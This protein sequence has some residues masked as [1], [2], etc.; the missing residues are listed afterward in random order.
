MI[1]IVLACE[2]KAEPPVRVYLEEIKNA[3]LDYQIICW[4][5][6]SDSPIHKN[7]K[8]CIEFSYKKR[9]GSLSSKLR[10]YWHFRRF[11]TKQLKALKPEKI[12]FIPTQ[13]GILLPARFFKK[14]DGCYYFDYRD[15]G[16]EKYGFYRKRVMNM[17]RHSF[18]TAISSKGFLEV[19][20]PSNKYVIAH[21]GYVYKAKKPAPFGGNP[22]YRI[23]SI[24]TLRTPEFV[25][26]E[27][28]PFIHDE[29]FEVHLYGT[30]DDRTVRFL[31]EKLDKES[32]GNVFYNG[33]FQDEELAS[34]IDGSDAL[35]VYYLSKIDGLYHMPDRLYLGLEYSKPMIANSETYCSRYLQENGIGYG[36]DPRRPDLDG[37]SRFLSSIN[38][39]TIYENCSTCL[40]RI[41]KENETW[42]TSIR[43]FLKK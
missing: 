12:I 8:G 10:N 5:P 16:Y 34:I 13:A 20:E 40:E 22:P 2:V 42:R 38:P 15:P 39:S 36:L 19:L 3:G 18:A 28:A 32:I 1:A 21:N 9:D 11:L 43:A 25:W 33:V 17:V 24:G 4:A 30:G 37:L 23:V 6:R 27:I 14:M 26:N 7:P 29:R 41:E 35:L 31:Q